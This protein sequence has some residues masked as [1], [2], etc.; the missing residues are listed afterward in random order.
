[1]LILILVLI[2]TYTYTYAYTLLEVILTLSEDF[3]HLSLLKVIFIGVEN[4]DFWSLED[5]LT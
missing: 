5:I 3:F 2:L 4:E 1:M